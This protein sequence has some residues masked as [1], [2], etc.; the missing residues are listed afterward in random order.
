F[1]AIRFRDRVFPASWNDQRLSGAVAGVVDEAVTGV[2]VVKAFAQEE[3]EFDRLTEQA[4]ELYQ[5]RMRTARYNARYSST[6]QALPMLAQL[7]V[8]A[9]G[10]WLALRGH[11]TLGVFLAFASY[12]VQIITPVRLVSS[13]LA[14]TQQARAGAERIFELLD[15]Q[16]RVADE[17]GARPGERIGLVGA[18]GSGK[19][20]LAYLIARFY[21]PTS[22]AVRL[23]GTD[24]RELTLESLRSTVN[25]V[26]EESF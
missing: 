10:G 26:F 15:L 4:H 18:S 8:L 11:I 1:F 12:L 22:G 14:T 7:G 17:P 24:V 9:L 2:R 19:S 16:P 21:D 20:T 6:L 3:R 23:D 25:V 13:L 5:S